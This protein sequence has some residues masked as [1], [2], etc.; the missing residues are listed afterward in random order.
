MRGSDP[1]MGPQPQHAACKNPA[2]RWSAHA[3]CA[4]LCVCAVYS[5]RWLQ[6]LGPLTL[7]VVVLC[8]A[9]LPCCA[10]SE[11]QE[12][13]WLPASAALLTYGVFE[14]LLKHQAQSVVLLCIGLAGCAEVGSIGWWQ[15]VA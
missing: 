15:G 4:L 10:L 5:S 14:G 13:W 11:H 12:S 9:A 2:H 8:R 1:S 6:R 3:D 7:A